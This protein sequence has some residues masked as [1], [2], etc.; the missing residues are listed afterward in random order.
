MELIK[1]TKGTAFE[2]CDF[3]VRVDGERKIKLLQLTDMQM[4]DGEQ[5]RRPDRLTAPEIEAWKP[6]NFDVLCGD[7]IRSLVAQTQPDLIFITGDITYGSFDDSGENLLWFCRLMDS[8]RI[9]WAPVF[10]NHDNESKKGITWQCEQ[11]ERSKYC[12]FRRGNVSGNGNYTVGIAVGEKLVRV[13]HMLDSNGCHS[14]DPDA[15]RKKGIYADQIDLV[16]SNTAK[17]Q[18]AQGE[19]VEAF[20]AF[21]IP[22]DC[23]VEAETRK[24]YCTDE[25]VSYSIGVDVP[26]LDGDFGCKGDDVRKG[27][28]DTGTGF[29]DFLKECNINGVFVGHCHKNNTCITYNGIRWVY[30]LKTGQYDDQYIGQ[31]GGTQITLGGKDFWVQHIPSLAVPGVYPSNASFVQQMLTENK[32]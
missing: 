13:L 9:P 31:M 30:G 22:V 8:F 17:I 23:F 10:G 7:H 1:N 12:M 20:L 14:E 5:R 3:V 4:I 24:G 32:R 15:I 21:H 28:I 18:A 26:S 16:R 25:R 27:V 11:F 2:G 29:M 19:G 6:E